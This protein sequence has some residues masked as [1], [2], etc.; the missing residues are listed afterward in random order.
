MLRLNPL[1][2]T[3]GIEAVG[4]QLTDAPSQADI[5]TL[6]NAFS[7][8][9]VLVVRDQRLEPCAMLDV[10]KRF[11]E[12]FEQHNKR[13]S[14]PECPEIHYIWNQERFPN[15][16]RYI[17][18]EG[19][20]TDHSN[21]AVPP[22]ATVLHAVKLPDSGGDT[23]F[24]DMASAYDGL[25]A[26]LKARVDGLQ[27][28]HVYQSSHSARKLMAV[29]GAKRGVVSD[30]VVHPLVRTH[31]ENGRRSL[32]LNPIRIERLV[33]LDNEVGLPL[34]DELLEHATQEK[35]QYRHQWQVGDLVMWDNRCLMHKANGDYDHSQDR[36]LL[37]VMLKGE[38]P[39]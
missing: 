15:G 16:R 38:K 7:Q 28:V 13:F 6:R 22:K 3:I 5:E 4:L 39:N 23:Q 14:L 25:S 30:E 36:Y 11:G 34:L 1:S 2:D 18:G 17:P 33:G 8:R 35:Y 31:P 29:E 27:A 10:V 21:D 12:V 37:R 20:H 32:Y 26:D 9:S 19:Y 24:V